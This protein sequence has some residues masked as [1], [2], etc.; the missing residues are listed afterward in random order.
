MSLLQN[1]I[2]RIIATFSLTATIVKYRTKPS[3]FTRST[4]K[5][6]FDEQVMYLLSLPR[7]SAQAALDRFIKEMGGDFTMHKQ[8]LFEAREKLSHRIFVDLNRDHFINNYAYSVGFNTYRGF[9]LIACDG[10][11]FDVPAGAKYFATLNIC[12]TCTKSSGGSIRRL[13]Q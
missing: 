4:A 11:V 6:T 13:P 1:F 5:L 2:G 9:R 7:R 10:S 3:Y 8:S 12:R